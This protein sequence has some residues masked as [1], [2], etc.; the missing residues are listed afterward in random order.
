MKKFLLPIIFSSLAASCAAKQVLGQPPIAQSAALSAAKGKRVLMIVSSHP[1]F[2]ENA[3]KTG[4]WLSEVTH[5]YHVLAQHGFNPEIASPEGKPGIMDPASFDLS[6]NI[7]KTFWENENLRA[8]LERPL[9]ASKLKADDYAVIYYAGGHGT[10]W[11][12][13]SSE[14]LARLAAGI[15]ERG[16][17]VSAVCHGPAGILNI[18][19]SNGEHLIKGKKVTGF[20]NFEERLAGKRSLVPYLLEDALKEKGADYSKAFIPFSGYAVTDGRLITGENP[21]SAGDVANAVIAALE[22][23]TP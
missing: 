19:L 13:P 16:G 7:N 10:L 17:I 22:K 5:F 20:T 21:K 6:D 8:K 23:P 3:E 1:Q 18:K 15:Y 4:Y 9:N 12:F 14:P 2:G 11:D